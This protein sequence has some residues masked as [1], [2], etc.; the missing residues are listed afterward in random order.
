MMMTVMTV[1]TVVMMMVIMIMILMM[2]TLVKSSVHNALNV[3]YWL[4]QICFT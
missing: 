2:M 1:M 3:Q 4:I